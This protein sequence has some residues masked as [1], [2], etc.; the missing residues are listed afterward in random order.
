MV[1]LG[2]TPTTAHVAG[3]RGE[4]VVLLGRTWSAVVGGP[5]FGGGIVYRQPVG[6]EHLSTSAT[7]RLRDPLM[8]VRCVALAG[9]ALALLVRKVRS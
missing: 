3:G 7:V 4:A 1:R 2:M 8:L 5:G 6:V 9:L